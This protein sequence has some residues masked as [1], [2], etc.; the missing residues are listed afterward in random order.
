MRMDADAHEWGDRFRFGEPVNVPPLTTHSEWAK[1]PMGTCVRT[2]ALRELRD[3]L[4][5]DEPQ[6]DGVVIVLNCLG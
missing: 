6:G 3:H 5:G 4:P 1:H 2:R